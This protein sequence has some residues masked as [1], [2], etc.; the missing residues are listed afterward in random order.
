MYFQNYFANRSIKL[1]SFTSHLQHSHPCCIRY[2][3]RVCICRYNTATH[4]VNSISSKS[5]EKSKFYE[6]L[7]ALDRTMDLYLTTS[8]N[9]Y[10]LCFQIMWFQ[11]ANILGEKPV[12]LT[13]LDASPAHAGSPWIFLNLSIR[14]NCKTM[15]LL[16]VH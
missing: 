14:K 3:T 5:L 11:L 9:M 10:F 16:P 6:E 15:R 8:A 1:E 2:Q 4:V 7:S 13:L 12:C